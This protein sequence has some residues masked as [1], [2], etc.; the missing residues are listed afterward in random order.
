MIELEEAID[1]GSLGHSCNHQAESEYHTDAEESDLGN[2]GFG[3][4]HEK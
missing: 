4:L 2:Q 1:V 3:L